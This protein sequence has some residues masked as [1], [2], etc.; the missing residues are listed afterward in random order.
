MTLHV[1][2]GGRLRAFRPRRR[3]RLFATDEMVLLQLVVAAVVIGTL[4]QPAFLTRSNLVNML[5]QSSELSVLVLAETIILIVGKFDLSLE[6]IVGVAPMLAAWLVTEPDI[7]GSGVGLNQYAALA[8]L[9]GTGLLI[10][11]FNGFLVIRLRLNAFIATL[12]MLILL[13]GV[14]VGL[15]DGRTLY[16]LPEALQY[17]GNAEWLGL[18]LSVWFAGVLYLVAGLILRYHRLGRAI[19]AVGGNAEASRAAGIQVGR[20]II[21]VYVLGGGLAAVAGLMLA[22][23]LASVTSSQG[24]NM[25]FT[26]FAAAV[27]GRIS[28]NGGKGTVLGALSGVVLLGIISNILELSNI[29]PFWI[30]ATY[31]AIILLALVAARMTSGK[32][33]RE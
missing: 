22:G 11:A 6:S 5:Q 23:R 18:P 24:Q 27:I 31:G 15:T 30:N 2:D 26:V 16:G 25:I 7:G 29:Q 32:A 1:Q 14:T 8:I 12:A 20:L 13:R 10:G 33:Y 17:L 28:L 4:L 21:G 19:Y 3:V 9:L